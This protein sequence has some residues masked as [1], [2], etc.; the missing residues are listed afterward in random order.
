MK[1]EEEIIQKKFDSL[2]HKAALNIIYTSNCLTAFQAKLLKP[3][4]ISY[5]QYNILRILRGQYPNAVNLKLIRSRMLDKM[6]DASRLVE[7]LRAKELVE[8]ETCSSD[9]RNID[10][11]ITKKGLNLLKKL[12]PDIKK[13]NK[14]MS[15]L[16]ND[17]LN[18]LNDLLDKL[19]G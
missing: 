17:E 1:L 15:F 16:N 11:C 4:N 7:K 13:L 10:I 8:R 6:S 12:D 3:Y 9:R 14:F 5:Q 2:Y 19:R 18:N